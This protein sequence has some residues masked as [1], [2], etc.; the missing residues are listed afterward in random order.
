MAK[1]ICGIYKIENLINGKVYIGQSNDIKRRWYHHKR[2]S[3]K[4]T[5]PS[6]NYPLY[7][8]FRKYGIDNFKFEIIEECLEEELNDKEIYYIELY[9][10]FIGFK[11]SNGYNQTLGG[12]G[13]RG[14]KVNSEELKIMSERMKGKFAK[15]LNPKAIKVECEGVVFDSVME[16]AECYNI[17]KSVMCNWISG[18]T[19]MPKEWY[20]KGL[21]DINKTMEDYKIRPND[22]IGESNLSCSILYDNTIFYS[23]ADFSNKNNIPTTTVW[24]WL[25]GKVAIPK[26]YEEKGLKYEDGHTDNIIIY[27]NEEYF[28]RV[29][30]NRS[31]C[32]KGSIPKNAKK[33]YCEGKLFDT[34]TKCAEYY[35]VNVGTMRGWIHGRDAMPKEWYN[36]G[37]RRED[38]CMKDYK[39][40]N[41]SVDKKV[42]CDNIE[43]DSISKCSQY[44]N[45]S[46]NAMRNWLS[47]KN[48][49][50]KRFY[51][52]K[53]HYKNTIFEDC[54]YKTKDMV[55]DAK[56]KPVICENIEYVS[57][58]ECAEYYNVNSGTMKDWLNGS[59]KMPLEW[60]NKGLHY[61]DKDMSDYKISAK[62]KRVICDGNIFNSCKECAEYYN[63]NSSTM[64]YW[65]S[66]KHN[67]PQQFKNKGLKYL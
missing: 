56:L 25:N 48:C 7:R 63:I 45:V 5:S 52:M 60:Y 50:P 49:M 13:S 32:R 51:D 61:K 33:V 30:K 39:I 23:L 43:F 31:E 38:K 6:Y 27:Q 17:S 22:R 47:G 10:S 12:E 36:K 37:L 2:D 9:T 16:C 44:Y 21:R 26:E 53:L 54:N 35:N 57:V 19:T 24:G 14:R 4:E 8:A 3:I 15:G 40:A 64:Q 59:N 42:I 41:E 28:E 20:D 11:D 66:G 46:Y 29:Q 1:K 62:K 58:K 34:V 67:M 55:I 65:L 18:R